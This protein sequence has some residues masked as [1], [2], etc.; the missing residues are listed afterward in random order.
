MGFLYRLKLNQNEIGISYKHIMSMIKVHGRGID[1]EEIG[2]QEGWVLEQVEHAFFAKR[3]IF[4]SED[5][6]L[7]FLLRY[8]TR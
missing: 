1:L 3:V 8:G 7:M 2:K 6:K 4:E 5:A